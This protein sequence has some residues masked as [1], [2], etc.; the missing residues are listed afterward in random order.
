MGVDR[1]DALVIGSGQGGKPLALR[2]ASEG[3]RTALV[4]RAA[5]GGTCVNYGCTPTKTMIASAR[6]G[7]LA[8]R[9]D[10]YGVRTGRVSIDLEKVRDRK[11]GIVESFRTGS[12][13]QV[14]GAENLELIRGE[15]RFTGP[16][17]LDVRLQ[18]GGTRRISADR[19]VIDTGTDAI[20]PD[21]PGLKEVDFLDS[22]S[23]MELGSVPEHLVILG[24]GVVALEFG[25]MFRRFG[26]RV[27]IVQRA[28]RLV[29]RE[30]VEISAEI[31]KIF[32]DD[33]IDVLLRARPRKVE[34]D[35]GG[36]AVSSETAQGERKAE[37]SHLLVAVGRAPNTVALAP[38]AAGIRTDEEGYIQV[39]ER[40]ETTAPGVYAI[41]DV[42]GGPAFTHISYDDHRILE[43]NLLGD[44]EA[45][46]VGRIVSYAVFTDP[47]LG[48]AGATEE[49]ARRLDR[50]IGVARLPMKKVARAL[51]TD[52]TRGLLKAVVDR[53]SEEILGC[54]FLGVHAGELMS[55]VH[56]AMMAKQP[57][58]LL[59]DAPFAHPTLAE[60]LNNLFKKIED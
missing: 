19:I 52:E 45:T 2:L 37:G 55:I 33:G 15:A 54:S 59:R 36:I 22:T 11:R 35:R 31:A 25:Q 7:H 13:K 56:L 21:L 41:G 50:R 47:E 20:V 1:Y 8:G 26:A 40:L 23:I 58:S 39:D 16:K 28:E 29:P 9:G 49:Q 38:D 44:G 42:K 6:V 30:D 46:T 3:S 34:R 4:E 51:E 32:A 53:E 24:G 18:D 17:E 12:E 43:R 60:A 10:D 48:R 57:Y 14:A 5:I 27:T